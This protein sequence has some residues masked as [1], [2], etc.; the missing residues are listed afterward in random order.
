MV[1]E[2]HPAIKFIMLWRIKLKV[3]YANNVN[4]NWNLKKWNKATFDISLI[5]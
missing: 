2:K 4:I 3:F 1:Y 5:G